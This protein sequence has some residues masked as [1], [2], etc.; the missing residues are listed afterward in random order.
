MRVSY[1]LVACGALGFA[2]SA[3]S[4]P[5]VAAT[6]PSHTAR[7]AITNSAKPVQPAEEPQVAQWRALAETGD[8][9]AQFQL[10][11]ALLYGKG[12]KASPPDAIAWFGKAAAQGH[13]EAQ[14]KYGF[15]LSF[16]GSRPEGVTWLARAAV[17]GEPQAAH[18]LGV[19]YWTGEGVP[20]D[21][22]KAYALM[23]R[24]E[25]FGIEKSAAQVAEMKAAFSPEDCAAGEALA[26]EIE[27]FG[28]AGDE[29][30]EQLIHR[31]SE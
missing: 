23:T 10:A 2:M 29:R 25:Q 24:A 16:T 12:V 27:L 18:L 6:S 20:E 13:R 4:A 19:F 8:A 26:L 1:R 14:Y 5:A 21:H 17:R 7:N 22:V 30:S 31:L 15:G 9:E 3:L 11:Q 28:R